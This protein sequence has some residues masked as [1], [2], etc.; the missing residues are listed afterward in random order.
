[1]RRRSRA[2]WKD[3]ACCTQRILRLP[4][5]PP[6]FAH[7]LLPP[8]LPLHF[9]MRLHLLWCCCM[10]SI[11]RCM[12]RYA[13]PTSCRREP[14]AVGNIVSATRR[15]QTMLARG[16]YAPGCD[17]GHVNPGA[18]TVPSHGIFILT[19][20]AASGAP[21]AGGTTRPTVGIVVCAAV[22][23]RPPTHSLR[24]RRD[25]SRWPVQAYHTH[26]VVL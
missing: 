23:D 7:I 19:Q 15:R 2:R 22:G 11:V 18:Y 1:M 21:V 5:H 10:P 9:L 26:H 24:T 20:L 3:T 17:T 12:P 14:V 8:S 13:A 6:S 25:G 16:R 4:R